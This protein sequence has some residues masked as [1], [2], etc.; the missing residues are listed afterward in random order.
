MG[1]NPNHVMVCMYAFKS[2][3]YFSAEGDWTSMY[4]HERPRHKPERMKSCNV[5]RTRTPVVKKPSSSSCPSSEVF[6]EPPSPNPC[7]SMRAAGRTKQHSMDHLAGAM[8][9]EVYPKP[10]ELH[11]QPEGDYIPSTQTQRHSL[12]TCPLNVP[13]LE[14][15]TFP[16]SH[17]RQGQAV[18][19]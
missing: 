5:S 15:F 4:E 13:C 12:G 2:L 11:F 10:V 17:H 16:A 3:L 1:L 6:P 9:L 14:N 19:P 7:R 8:N 18:H